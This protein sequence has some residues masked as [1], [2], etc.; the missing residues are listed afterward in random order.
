MVSQFR[1]IVMS[2]LI[3]RVIS[4]LLGL[5]FAYWGSSIVRGMFTYPNPFALSFLDTF[6]G[7]FFVLIAFVVAIAFIAF[8][9]LGPFWMK[10]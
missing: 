5:G 2:F 8:A 6:G 7:L 9:A 10:H 1:G 4:L 3:A